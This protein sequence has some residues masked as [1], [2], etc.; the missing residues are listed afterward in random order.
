[1]K[2]LI[3]T[4]NRGK[5]IEISNFLQGYF[6]EFFYL[7][8][9]DGLSEVKED[10]KTFCEN[11]LKKA[12]WYSKLVDDLY[13]LGDDSGLMVD[14]LNG[15][16]GV[17]SSR[18]AGENLSD[19][20]KYERLLEKMSD[21]PYEKRTAKFVSCITLAKNGVEIFTVNGECKGYILFSPRG[22][23]G[24]GYDPIFYLPELDK[25]FA[26][27]TSE[28]KNRISHRGRALKKFLKKLKETVL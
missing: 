17:Y 20:E 19:R 11:S 12:I 16:P 6:D 23:G 15:F 26:E 4:G 14:E 2:L 25:T 10:G 5:F 22:V 18:W 1:M 9:F 27:L 28:E 13:V 3:A 24:F 7:K 21:I 8:D